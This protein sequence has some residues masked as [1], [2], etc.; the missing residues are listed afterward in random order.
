[1]KM[2]LKEKKMEGILRFAQPAIIMTVGAVILVLIVGYFVTKAVQT[3]N[4]KEAAKK[5]KIGTAVIVALLVLAFLWQ[6]I[7]ALSINDVN[8][9]VIDRSG[10]NQNRY[11]VTSTP[12]GK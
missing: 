3:A 6:L 9:S 2:V 5:V 11:Q 7:V 10:I 8:R 4:G 1:M 12:Y